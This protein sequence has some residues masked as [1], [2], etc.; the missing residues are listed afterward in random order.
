MSLGT[1]GVG[2]IDPGLLAALLAGNHQT[3]A[4]GLPPGAMPVG[5][6]PL[7]QLGG[8][9][10]ARPGQQGILQGLAPLAAIGHGQPLSL[11]HLPQLQ[12]QA[13]APNAAFLQ[14]L[15]HGGPK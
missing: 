10:A 15:H 13:L 4:V 9:T 11:A 8:L 6:G 2:S 14:H 3:A 12:I 7:L 1:T 5:L